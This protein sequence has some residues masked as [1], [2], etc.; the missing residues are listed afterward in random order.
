MASFG[1][2]IE[3]QLFLSS[4]LTRTDAGISRRSI[5]LRTMRRIF[6]SAHSLDGVRALSRW[7][8]RVW[9]FQGL[10]R[11]SQ[12]TLG[13]FFLIATRISGAFTAA[14]DN[15]GNLSAIDTAHRILN[16]RAPSRHRNESI[17]QLV[18]GD[19]NRAAT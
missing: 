13:P 1:A 12:L 14:Y 11:K 7:V 19:P 2:R 16:A 9:D 10:L 4:Q 3:R 8:P 18:V 6:A 17:V 5:R 15:A